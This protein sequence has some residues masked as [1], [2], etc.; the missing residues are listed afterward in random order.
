[1]FVSSV[2]DDYVSLLRVPLTSCDAAVLCILGGWL[3]CGGLRAVEASSA[4]E[5]R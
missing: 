3:L 5:F 1:M 2:G 4:K